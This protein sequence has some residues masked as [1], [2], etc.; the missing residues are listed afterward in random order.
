M[1]KERYKWVEYYKGTDL[2]KGYMLDKAKEVY[3][4]LQLG[5]SIDNINEA[6]QLYNI[7]KYENDGTFLLYLGEHKIEWL[8]EKNIIAKSLVGKYINCHSDIL[9]EYQDVDFIYK[10]SF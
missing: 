2:A 10:E 1:V 6:L 4:E 5:H 9:A 3:D 7:M 8:K